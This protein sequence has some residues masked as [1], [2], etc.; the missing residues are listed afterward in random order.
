MFS[1]DKCGGKGKIVKG[2]CPVC[3][4]HKVESGE[5]TITV[6][7]EKGMRDGHEIVRLPFT[8]AIYHRP[9]VHVR[10]R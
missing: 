4:G 7:V 5:D 9:D 2:T 8:I 1:C 10:A 6:I 3:K